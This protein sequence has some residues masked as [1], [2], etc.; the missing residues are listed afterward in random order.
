M[1]QF[2]QS[3]VWHSET[4]ATISRL[5]A[6]SEETARSLEAAAEAQDRLVAGQREAME[7]Q[8]RVVENGTLLSKALE[9]SRGNVKEILEEVGAGVP[10]VLT[11]YSNRI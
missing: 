1:C 7:Y 11:Y 3:Q 6:A 10:D 5:S 4:Q 9:A 8:R 2:L